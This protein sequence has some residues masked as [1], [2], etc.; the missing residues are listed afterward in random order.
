MAKVTPVLL[1]A[2]SS[3]SPPQY[4]VQYSCNNSMTP[5]IR[6]G[7]NHAN[8]K[9]FLPSN[10]RCRRTYSVHI[11]PHVPPYMTICV[12]LSTNG[13]SSKGSISGKGRNDN[14]H[15]STIQQMLKGYFLTIWS[16]FCRISFISVAKVR[17]ILYFCK[18]L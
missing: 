18:R 16:V 11:T 15:I 5:L 2:K 17:I 14:I 7:N 3:C 1:A 8:K 10:L 4:V 9:S 6:M 12:H 13:T